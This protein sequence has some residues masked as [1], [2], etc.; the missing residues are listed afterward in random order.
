GPEAL[1]EED[2]PLAARPEPPDDHVMLGPGQERLVEDRLV[3]PHQLGRPGARKGGAELDGQ[4]AVGPADGR[5]EVKISDRRHDCAS[6]L[7][8]GVRPLGESIVRNSA[9]SLGVLR[10]E[11][12]FAPRTRCGRPMALLRWPG[13]PW[14]Q[15][16]Q[17]A[18]ISARPPVLPSRTS[19]R[20]IIP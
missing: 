8:P 9:G 5:S 1:A 18:T 14:Y 2:D 11:E 7:V 16:R 13:L 4:A 3:T 17:A 12:G 19:H 20:T 10:S 6:C 15:D